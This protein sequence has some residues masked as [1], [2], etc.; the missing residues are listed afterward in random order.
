MDPHSI[1]INNQKLKLLFNCTDSNIDQYSQSVFPTVA[2]NSNELDNN[3]DT[4]TTGLI[5]APSASSRLLDYGLFMKSSVVT[6]NP[7]I[8]TKIIEETIPLE[9]LTERWQ[10]CLAVLY[11]LT[12]ITS[13]IL[14]V[15]TVIVLSRIKRSE[16]TKY[17]INLS[18]SDLLMSLF[19][20]PFTYTEYMLGRW[21]FSSFLC[22]VV[23]FVVTL[24]VFVSVAT[25]TVIGVNR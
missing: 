11:S 9:A 7:P 12:A 3:S 5:S 23:R 2:S 8:N 10:L 15:A 19:S 21:I 18:V 17:L 24:S 22:P 4:F 16:L 1:I 20:I 13:F 14:N 6:T 25:M